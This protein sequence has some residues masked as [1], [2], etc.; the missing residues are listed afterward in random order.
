MEMEGKE[1]G[2]FTIMLMLWW[3]AGNC[4]TLDSTV[5]KDGSGN[6][7]TIT[8]AVH[9]APKH[10]KKPY[11]IHVKAGIYNENVTVPTD[12][13]N[14][15]LI[16]DG[17]GLTIITAS[18]SE[19]KK[20]ATPN[21]ATLEVYGSGFIGMRMTIRNTAGAIGC[22]A[23][24][25]TSATL[26]NGFASYYQC[27]FEGFQ[28]T[29]FAQ[30]GSAFFRECKVF[31]TIDF[32][33]GDG[34]AVFQ[35][36]AIYARTPMHGQGIRILAPGVDDFTPNPGLVL[37]NCSIFPAPGKI[38]MEGKE[39]VIFTIVLMLWW[40]AGNCVI[41]DST[42]AKDGSRKY[43]T[44]TEVVLIF[45][46]LNEIYGTGFIGMKMAIRNTAGAEGGQ[47][48]A[49]ANAPWHGFASYYQCQFEGLRK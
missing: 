16:G 44:I 29:I 4:L 21:T 22:Q 43:K 12:K 31:G 45:K 33:A 10:S 37:Q 5:A 3:S 14:I 40:S 20:F 17:I 46:I 36:S 9:A 23:A 13:T 35:N 32:I 11:Y 6:Y 2:I 8:E 24:A 30:I 47:A 18:K 42:V 49:L 25:L 7:K 38:E 48:A 28:D 41:F 27:S 1:V 26:F 19:T 34:K 15:A 39:V